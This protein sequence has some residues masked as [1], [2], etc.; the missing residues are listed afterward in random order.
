MVFGVRMNGTYSLLSCGLLLIS[1]YNK[2]GIS[3][4]GLCMYGK[5]YVKIFL[6]LFHGSECIREQATLLFVCACVFGES[7][8][9]SLHVS[10]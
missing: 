8:S 1:R 9:A 4:V 3:C 10:F 2:K 7:G 5:L 6:S